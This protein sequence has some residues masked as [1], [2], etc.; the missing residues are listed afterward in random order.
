MGSP[1]PNWKGKN[2]RG[3][4]ASVDEKFMLASVAL[5]LAKPSRL[6]CGPVMHFGQKGV[7]TSLRQAGTLKP[8]LISTNDTQNELTAADVA[9]A[10]K[11]LEAIVALPRERTLWTAIRFLLSALTEKGWETR[12]VWLWVVLEALFGPDSPGETTYRLAQRIA[13]F[14]GEENS[15]QERIFAATKQAYGWRSKIVH[16]RHLSRL[17]SEGSL[18]LSA[19]TEQ[20]IRS[21]LSKILLDKNRL[22]I[23]DGKGRDTFLD[24]LLFR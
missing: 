1:D 10:S 15:E 24:G 22:T 23:F 12:F 19:N 2:P 4:Q 9:L 21:A 5:W 17:T 3:I 20:A 14:V 6:T 7:S 13:L 8:I 16:G 18:E 11:L